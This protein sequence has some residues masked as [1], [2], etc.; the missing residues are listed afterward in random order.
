ML[1]EFDIPIDATHYLPL[2]NNKNVATMFY[3]FETI[4][5]NDNT[6]KTHLMY[7]SF[8]NNWFISDSNGDQDFINRLIKI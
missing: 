3:K 6:F 2:N 5:Y 8:S 1:K 4:K 7:L